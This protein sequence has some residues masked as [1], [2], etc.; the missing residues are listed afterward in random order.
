MQGKH[1]IFYF[2]PTQLCLNLL[3]SV[4]IKAAKK[5]N[6]HCF[7]KWNMNKQKLCY[8]N[9]IWSQKHIF[10][11]G[12]R[13]FKFLSFFADF[14]HKN[15]REVLKSTPYH[16]IFEPAC[17]ELDIADTFFCLVF[18]CVCVCPDVGLVLVFTCF[19]KKNLIPI[20]L[21]H[22]LIFQDENGKFNF[23]VNS[24]KHTET[25]EPVTVFFKLF[26]LSII[27]F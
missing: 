25:G 10:L 21:F 27:V 6:V 18:V 15:K 24:V 19:Y 4:L 14:V 7:I 13:G 9:S 2:W 8:N 17:G 20:I 26:F 1:L 16:T 12:E 22:W 11:F 3:N 23:D 5:F